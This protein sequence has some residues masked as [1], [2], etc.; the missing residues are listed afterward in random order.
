MPRSLNLADFRP[1]PKLVVKQTSVQKPHCRVIDAHNHLGVDFGGG[2]A[3]KSVKELTDRLDEASV[4][5]YVDLDGGWSEAILDA[6]LRKF[7]EA[8]PERFI[9]FGGPGWAHWQA[10]GDQFGEKAAQRFRAQVA[11]GAQG[12]KIWK[13]F[14]LH[15]RDQNGTL[16]RVNDTRL[17]ALWNAVDELHLPVMIHVADPVA[18]FDPL[19]AT[20]ERWDELNAHPEWQFPVPLFP[21]FMSIMEDFARLVMRF[22]NLKFIAAHVG[23][24]AE[25]LEWVGNLLERCPNLHIDISARISEL[26]RQPY[27]AKRFLERFSGRVLFGIDCGPNL[28][29]YRTYYRFLETDDEYFSY[30][31]EAAPSQGRWNIYG[32]NLQASVLENIYY[33]NAANLFGLTS[34]AI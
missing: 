28:D 8:V 30:D 5:V 22:P 14:G 3:N 13:D 27:S 34:N 1:V 19:D 11:R 12:L 26:G 9:F 31:K 21:S 23:C 20:N 18:F 17:D 24:Y 33:N 16:V 15:V 29:A 32:L 10:D 6:R 2:W 4:D 25:N 7:K